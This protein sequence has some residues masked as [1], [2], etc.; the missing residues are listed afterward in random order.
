MWPSPR[1]GPPLAR[2]RIPLT[3]PPSTWPKTSRTIPAAAVTISL[4]CTSGTVTVVDATATRLPQTLLT[5]LSPASRRVPLA[6]RRSRVHRQA[7]RSI[8][9]GALQWLSLLEAPRLA[10]SSTTI[11]WLRASPVVRTSRASRPRAPPA[12]QSPGARDS[13]RLRDIADAGVTDCTES[14]ASGSTFPLGTTTVTCS[15]T[16]VAGNAPSSTASTSRPGHDGPGRHLRRGHHGRGGHRSLG[17]GS[18]LGAASARP[19][20][21]RRRHHG[22]QLDADLRRHVPA[23]DDDGDLQL[24][25][26]FGE[27]RLGQL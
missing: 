8:R 22:L 9:P 1:R 10:R 16:D 18:V 7:T 23:G 21:R 24:H 13:A 25:R 14:P 20:R 2:S 27:H 4:S 26:R 12:L 6:R 5:S 17:S 15:Y 11:W 19:P 3:Q